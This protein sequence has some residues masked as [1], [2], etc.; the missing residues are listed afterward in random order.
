MRISDGSSDV[1]SSDLA[2]RPGG[3]GRWRRPPRAAPAARSRGQRGGAQVRLPLL[4]HRTDG[5]HDPAELGGSSRPAPQH[6]RR[7]DEEP[8]ALA[9]VASTARGHHVLPLVLPATAAGHDVVDALGGSTAV[10]AHVVV[11]GED[12]APVEGSPTRSEEH[13][14]ELQ[15]LMRISYAVF[16]L[17]KKKKK[18][19]KNK[20]K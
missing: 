13:T 20:D 3:R 12:P 2:P 11:A 6:H 7:V 16:C 18:T 15:S 9:D 4:G 10:L 8:V 1:C 14:S 17:K 19:T 5:D